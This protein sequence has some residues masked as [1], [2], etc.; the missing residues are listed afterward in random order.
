[1]KENKYLIKYFRLHRLLRLLL[2]VLGVIVLII[3]ILDFAFV[4]DSPSYK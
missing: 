2:I 1:M 3:F 4:F